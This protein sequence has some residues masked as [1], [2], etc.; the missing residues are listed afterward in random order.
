[1]PQDNSLVFE[2]S[3]RLG[4]RDSPSSYLPGGSQPS[5]EL[6][7]LLDSLPLNAVEAQVLP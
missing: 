3:S 4:Q 6:S 5:F 2:D 1:M 7:S